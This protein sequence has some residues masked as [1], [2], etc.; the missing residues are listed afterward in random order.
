MNGFIDLTDQRFGRLVAIERHSR[1]GRVTMWLCKC[2]CGNKKIVRGT[3]LRNGHTQSCGCLHKE[4]VTKH[5]STRNHGT[6]RS[7]LYVV[8]I[9][10]KARCCNENFPAFKHYGGRG[11]AICEE[12]KNEFQAFHEWAMANGYDEKAKR[13]DCTIDR[14]DVNGNYC[15][16]NCRWVDMK[17]QA[18]NKRN[19]KNRKEGDGC[20]DRAA[21]DVH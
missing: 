7:R 10:M 21:E 15:P 20:V 18:N 3:D 1:K 14:I 19:S 2:D 8:W 13:G 11:I 6:I 12:W 17:V 5:G 4:A 16:E 9:D